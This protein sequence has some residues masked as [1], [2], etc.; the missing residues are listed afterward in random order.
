[1]AEVPDFSFFSNYSSSNRLD[2]IGKPDLLTV[3]S[4]DVKHGR[5]MIATMNKQPARKTT[6]NWPG[7][8][9]PRKRGRSASGTTPT[10]SSDNTHPIA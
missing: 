9:S 4:Q 2:V 10:G 6:N 8:R 3:V 1:M 7:C 5:R